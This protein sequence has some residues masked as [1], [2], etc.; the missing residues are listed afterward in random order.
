MNI[1]VL[2]KI[3]EGHPVEWADVSLNFFTDLL[4]FIKSN[5][6][7]VTSINNWKNNNIGDVVLTFDDG[8]S[9]DFEFAYPLL[10]QMNI[11]ATFFIVPD[12]V[13]TKGYMTWGNIKQLSDSG[14]EIASHSMSHKYLNSLNN[15]TILLE[16]KDSKIKIEQMIGKEV[17]SFAY[18]YGD[19]SRKTNKLATEAGYINICNSKPG[20]CRFNS[21]I[22]SRSSIHSNLKSSDMDRLIFPN[23]FEQTFQKFGYIVRTG[24]KQTL[25]IK[26]YVKLRELI[27]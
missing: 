26:N 20:L 1:L 22:L 4:K 15:E 19:C 24:L 27:Y 18:P 14:M 6:L 25:G 5:N 17:N 2:H 7:I 11:P 3:V 8:F 23:E 12:F 16:L 10:K 13:G 9:S 21:T